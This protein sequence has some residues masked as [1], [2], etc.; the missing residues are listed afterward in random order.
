MFLEHNFNMYKMFSN[1]NLL[2]YQNYNYKIKNYYYK[3][4]GLLL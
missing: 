1:S 2:W 4:D 3:L